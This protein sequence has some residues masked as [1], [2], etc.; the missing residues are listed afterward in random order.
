MPTEREIEA[1]A[2]AIEARHDEYKPTRKDYA[3]M[4]RAALEAAERERWQPAETAPKDGSHFLADCHYRGMQEVW[5]WHDNFRE[6]YWMDE[7]DSEPVFEFW[8]PLPER[9]YRSR[10]LTDLAKMDAEEIAE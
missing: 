10:A 6:P 4:A 3:A 1:A 9:S 2:K 7:S 5:W 8:M